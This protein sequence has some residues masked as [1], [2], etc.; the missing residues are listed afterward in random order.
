MGSIQVR[1]AAN[2]VKFGQMTPQDA[3][4]VIDFWESAVES[5]KAAIVGFSA[6]TLNPVVWAAGTYFLKSANDNLCG[7]RTQK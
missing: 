4:E 5:S 2:N 1:D 3:L 7:I 6:V